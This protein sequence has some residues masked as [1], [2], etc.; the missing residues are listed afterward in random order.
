M[1][2]RNFEERLGLI[3]KAMGSCYVV[4]KVT[5]S[6]SSRIEG[7]LASK[8]AELRPAEEGGG[9]GDLPAAPALGKKEAYFG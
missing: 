7:V 9:H 8:P 2:P 4:I 3:R 6:G 5:A 1:K